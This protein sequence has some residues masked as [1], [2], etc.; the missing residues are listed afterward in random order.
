MTQSH[1]EIQEHVRKLGSNLMRDGLTEVTVRQL[2]D[3]AE[4]FATVEKADRAK[5]YAVSKAKVA[6]VVDHPAA[7]GTVG[8]IKAKGA[9]SLGSQGAGE[10]QASPVSCKCGW[11]AYNNAAV[12]GA[13]HEK[14]GDGHDVTYR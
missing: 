6:N 1:D 14:K 7:H 11:W 5:L 3:F 8:P 13:K 9:K 2:S 12:K 4:A 10:A